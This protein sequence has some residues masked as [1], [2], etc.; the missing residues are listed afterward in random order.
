MK[1]YTGGTPR[2]KN[3]T[4]FNNNKVS[5][6]VFMPWRE[7]KIISINPNFQ[8]QK[9][10]ERLHKKIILESASRQELLIGR[11]FAKT[12]SVWNLLQIV[13][14]VDFMKT[15]LTK[16][17]VIWEKKDQKAGFLR[18]ISSKVIL[19]KEGTRRKKGREETQQWKHS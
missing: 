5:K 17:A 13:S 15:N 18:P 6:D 4:I 14:P 9:W 3:I 19:A 8:A 1:S 2:F 10:K 7:K 16:F 11:S 12:V